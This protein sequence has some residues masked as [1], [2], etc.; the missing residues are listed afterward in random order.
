MAKSKNTIL[1]SLL[2]AAGDIAVSGSGSLTGDLTVQGRLTAQEYH[3]EIVSSSILYTSGST[4]FGDS[5][6]DTHQFTGSVNISGSILVNG[7]AAVGP[8]GATGV[9]P[10]SN[11][12]NVWTFTGD[13]TTTT[14]TLTGNI[15]GSLNGTAFTTQYTG[16]LAITSTQRSTLTLGHGTNCHRGV[17]SNLLIRRRATQ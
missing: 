3:S 1:A 10:A 7:V 8:Q 14:W 4:K 6:D 5:A 11:A 15:S 2:T 13:G 9:I 12:G 17:V 16:G